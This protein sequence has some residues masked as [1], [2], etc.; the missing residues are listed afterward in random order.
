MRW[1]EFVS[2]NLWLKLISLLLA[3]LVWLAARTQISD[4]AS[5][6]S[7]F[8]LNEVERS[9]TNLAIQVLTVP[10]DPRAFL[11]DP[12]SAG[13][14]ISG[15]AQLMG[16]L[17]EGDLGVFVRAPQGGSESLRVY[18]T[19]PKGIN[20]LQLRPEA[21]LVTVKPAQTNGARTEEIRK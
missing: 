7:G 10:A 18:A 15:P 14:R 2:H 1:R 8:T 11:V 19:V 9:F 17:V 20:V 16:R 6:P 13:F 3:T 5:V 21:V 12:A 4:D